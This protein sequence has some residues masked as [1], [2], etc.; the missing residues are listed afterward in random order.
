MASDAKSALLLALT[1]KGSA[2]KGGDEEASEE[3]GSAQGIL[4]AIA[5]K[6]AGSLKAALRGFVSECMAS[7]DKEDSEPEAE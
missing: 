6:D 1:P 7:Y 2:P 5:A 3:G 4:D